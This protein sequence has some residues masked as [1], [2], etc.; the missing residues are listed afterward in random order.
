MENEL[1][2]KK[3]F[4]IPTLEIVAFTN[5]DIIT[6]SG[7]FGLGDNENGDDFPKVFWW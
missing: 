1:N 3:V 7:D 5:D 6:G 4:I 2:N